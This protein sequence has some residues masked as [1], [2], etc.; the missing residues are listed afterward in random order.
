METKTCSECR[1]CKSIEDFNW[2]IKNKE[3]RQTRCKE[4][5]RKSTINHYNSNKESYKERARVFSKMQVAEN[6]ENLYKYLVSHPC[7]DCG[8]K[9]PVVLQMDHVRG[10]KDSDVSQLVRKGYCWETIQKEIEKCEVRCANCHARKTAKQ[11]GWSK[12]R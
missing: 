11:F 2:R 4:C 3:I 7:T 12:L 10:T 8:E 5:T 6:R 9:D 1:L